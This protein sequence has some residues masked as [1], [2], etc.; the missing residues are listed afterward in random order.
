[1]ALTVVVQMPVEDRV[2]LTRWTRMPVVGGWARAAGA[3]I[4]WLAEEG[5]GTNEIVHRVG[6]SKPR[7]CQ[8]FCVSGWWVFIGGAGC[9]R[10]GSG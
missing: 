2:E 8:V 5:V 1:M 10:G 6:V 9:G 4:V 3:R 7:A